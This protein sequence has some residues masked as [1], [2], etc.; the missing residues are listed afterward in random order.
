MRLITLRYKITSL[1][2]LPLVIPQVCASGRLTNHCSIRGA[3]CQDLGVA[4]DF[5]LGHKIKVLMLK[6]RQV[7]KAIIKPLQRI[8]FRIDGCREL[9]FITTIVVT[10]I[11]GTS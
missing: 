1:F 4:T 9:T 5:K 11:F 8:C 7:R 6:P 3:I 2:I 10:L